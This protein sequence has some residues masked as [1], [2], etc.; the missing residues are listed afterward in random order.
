MNFSK[1]FCL[2]FF[3]VLKQVAAVCPGGGEDLGGSDEDESSD[4]EDDDDDDDDDDSG[5][6]DDEE[7]GE[8]QEEEEEVEEPLSLEWPET[9][10]KQITYLLLLPIVFPLW[11]TVPDVRNPVRNT[12]HCVSTILYLCSWT[13]FVYPSMTMKVYQ[14]LLMFCTRTVFT[15]YIS[16]RAVYHYILMY[17]CL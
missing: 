16:M 17:F 8:E 12:D 7:A 14:A 2:C 5:D 11:L 1:T 9:R 15:L 3:P 4:D 6:Q 10:R 13:V